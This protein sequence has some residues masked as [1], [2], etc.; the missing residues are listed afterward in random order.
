M[1]ND[2]YVLIIGSGRITH[3]TAPAGGGVMSLGILLK[4]EG[5]N[6]LIAWNNP[7]GTPELRAWLDDMKEANI[8]VL[9]VSNNNKKR[10]AKAVSPFGVDFVSRAIKP[11]TRGMKMASKKLNLPPEKMVMVG[12]QIMTDI[13]ASNRAGIRSVRVKPLV[14]S[15][16]WITKFNRARERR[17]MK[18]LNAAYD[19]SFKKEI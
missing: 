2:S 4:I 14:Q 12:D 10:I 7:D 3:N 13:H 15:D 16:A 18:K 6:T 9:V 8:P 19:M 17:M 1:Q 11:F 5:S